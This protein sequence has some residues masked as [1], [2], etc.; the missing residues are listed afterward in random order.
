MYTILPTWTPKTG[1]AATQN[2]LLKLKALQ[3]MAKRLEE[4][5]CPGTTAYKMRLASNYCLACA[6][7]SNVAGRALTQGVCAMCGVP[8]THANT[9]VPML[10]AA[11]AQRDHLCRRCG[12]DMSLNLQREWSASNQTVENTPKTDA[13]PAM[14]Q[15]EEDVDLARLISMAMR[16]NH[17]FGLMG[18]AQQDREIALMRDLLNVIARHNSS[19][20]AAVN[21]DAPSDSLLLC[22]AKS[23]N[24]NFEGFDASH[25][26]G[27]LTEMR[28]VWEEASGN[29]FYHPDRNAWYLSDL[30]PIG[31]KAATGLFLGEE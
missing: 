27:V 25:R 16:R 12:G 24:S 6:V 4:A 10:C 19:V 23:L 9:D 31:S 15:T 21:A 1:R 7:N 11:C 26:R 18:R 8:F 3:S 5:Q 22:M 13:T 30:N 2:S 29:G 14:E 28:Q 17:G 20:K